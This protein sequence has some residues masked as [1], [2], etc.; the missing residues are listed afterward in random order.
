MLKELL[1]EQQPVVYRALEN[2]CVN[3]EVSSAYL[4]AGPYGTPKKEAAI[5]LAQSIF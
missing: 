1:K 4:F 2:A 5:L 3:H